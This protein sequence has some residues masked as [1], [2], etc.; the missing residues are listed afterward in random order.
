MKSRTKALR[1]LMGFLCLLSLGGTSLSAQTVTTGSLIGVITD[2]QGGVLPGATVSA[3]HTPTNTVYEAVTDGEGRYN[4]LNL[5]VGPYTVSA[6]MSGFRREERQNVP[7]TLGEQRT[8]DF[9]LSLETIAETVDVVAAVSIIDSS[10]AGTADNVSQASVENLPTISRNLLDIA[11]TSPY[12]NPIGLNDDP[13]AISVAGRNNR[14]NNVQIDGAVYNDVFGLA[15]SGAPGGQTETQPISLD[16]IQEL[17]LVVSPYDVRQGGFS[18]GGINAITK[19]GT[20]DFHGTGY[21]FGRNQDW[22][23]ESPTGTKVGQ[24]KDQQFG[25]S[26]GGRLVRNRAFFF[27]NVDWSRRDNPSGVSVSGSGQEFGRA[28]EI[29]RFLAILRTRYGYDPG[30]TDEFIRTVDSDKIFAR[31]DIN[32]TA[33]HR[34]T[35]RHNYLDALNDIGR[36]D[37]QT[38]FMPDNF[39]RIKNKTNSFVTQLNS[40]IG[41]AVNEL[42]FTYTRVRDRRGAQPFEER[43]FP[44]VRVN[45]SSGS[46][47]AGRENFSTA[48]ELDQDVIEINNDLT[49]LRGNHT[50]TL[51]TH[52]EFFDFRNLFIRDNFGNYTFNSL[53]LFEQ[54][55]AQSFDYSFSLTGNP[56]QPAEFRVRQY[57]FYVGDQWRPLSDLTLTFGVR[58]DIPTFPDKPTA[59]PASEAAFG[60][61]TDEVPSGVL[62]SP[63]IGFNY[64]LGSNNNEQIRGGFGLFSGRTPYVW[65]SNQ[66]GNTGIEFR[67]ISVGFNANNRIP[68]SADPNAQPTNIGNAATNE[69][70]LIDPDY[71]Y[72]SLIRTNLAYDR[73]LGFF[74]LIGT[75]EFL[76][77]RNVND[78]KYQNLNL[79]Q[80]G[81]RPDGRPLF[82]RNLVPTLSDV[83]FLTNTDEGDSW[84][85]VFKVDRPIRNGFFANG[86]YLYG[87]SQSIM[88]GQSSQAASNWGNV[89]V[90]GDTNNPPLTR[91]NFDPGHRVTLSGGY[92]IPLGGGFTATASAFYS[93]QSGRPYSLSYNLDYNGDLRGFND[94]VYIPASANEVQFINGT[95]ADFQQFIASEACLSEYVGQIHERNACRSPWQ[96]TFD[97]RVNVG[98]PFSRIKAEITWDLLNVLNLTG[99]D[100]GLV[101]WANFNQLT[102]IRPTFASNGQPIYNLSG[103]FR[104][105]ELQTPEQLMVRDDL[106]SRWQMQLGARIRF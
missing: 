4:I 71:K 12:F 80:V 82:Q 5:R 37:L 97:F 65:L 51:G 62:W 95:F 29:D 49:W 88:D 77:S 69:I 9:R 85:I 33:Q 1:S 59:N 92:E 24:F 99:S 103:L 93:G 61:R 18:G 30:G 22:V 11:R 74:G 106:R 31:G 32:L 87:R 3:V 55:L 6:T 13:L 105:G 70:D 91:S 36:P 2:A 16:A 104:R 57:G 20:N 90:P 89:Y 78:I 60:Y 53:D 54:G 73:N 75:T 96:N 98:L 35:A 34:L 72:P 67:R 19:S 81:T 25:A 42:R 84:S 17:Q 83:I 86:S 48:N 21:F 26:L 76:Y 56:K 38:Y 41:S 47:R 15:A 58:A 14:Y 8:V 39:Y 100:N 27:G 63:R 10:R 28:A 64:A 94:L 43:P 7:V 79:R 101:E 66:F 68:F 50:L 102:V 44:F 45:L 46:V 52:N 23:G 40:T